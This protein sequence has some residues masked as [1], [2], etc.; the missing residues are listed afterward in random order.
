MAGSPY[1]GST[2]APEL[3][4]FG[5]RQL[6]GEHSVAHGR[7]DLLEVDVGDPIREPFDDLHVV[8]VAVG[9]VAGVEAEVH[10]LRVGV[11]QEALDPLLGVD[12]RVDVRVEHQLDAELLEQVAG[13]LV[14]ARAPG[15][16]SRPGRG[17][18]PRWT[19]RCACRCTASG[20]WTRY[21][22]PT[23]RSSAGL[24]A[25]LLLGLVERLLALVQA[26]E[27]GAAADLQPA[28]VELVAQ[29]GRVLRQEALRPE[30]GPHVTR[31]RQLVEVLPPGHLVR[32]LA[33]TTPPRSPV[34]CPASAGTGRRV[35]S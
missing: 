2:I 34:R 4:G 12:V 13:Q 27:H 20:R 10:V 17:R 5:Q 21:L 19:R 1:G 3:D 26:G 31:L 24:A 35:W 6:L 9:D 30:L 11:G 22:A 16:S 25:E 18:R 28:L 7:V 33:G 32:V 8:A 15:S 23:S 14:G 29:L